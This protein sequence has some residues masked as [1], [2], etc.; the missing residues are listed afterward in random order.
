MCWH[1]QMENYVCCEL[2][3]KLLE[4]KEI[5][6]SEND[7]RNGTKQNLNNGKQTDTGRNLGAISQ[8]EFMKKH[9]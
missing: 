6:P 2:L 1:Q 9:A 4:G 7:Q 5:I 3:R 8:E